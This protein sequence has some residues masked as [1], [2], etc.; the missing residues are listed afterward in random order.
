[1]RQIRGYTLVAGP[2]DGQQIALDEAYM[3]LVVMK[4]RAMPFVRTALDADIPDT[5]ETIEYTP[6]RGVPGVLAPYGTAPELVIDMLVQKY[7]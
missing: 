5:I 2:R 1:M 4:P 6:V 3:R 7:A